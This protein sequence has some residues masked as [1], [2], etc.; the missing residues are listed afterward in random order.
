DKK[1]AS[2]I[3][4]WLLAILLIPSSAIPF[5]FM[6]QR[7]DKRS[8]WQ[9]EAMNF[10]QPSLDLFCLDKSVS[11]LHLPNEIINVFANMDLNT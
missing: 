10:S 5:F 7:K 8:F 1:S 9:K 4:A 2:L 11:C 6:F 3:L